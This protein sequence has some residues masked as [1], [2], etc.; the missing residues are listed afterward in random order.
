MGR[1]FKL[2]DNMEEVHLNIG[3]VVSV[4]NRYAD[5]GWRVYYTDQ[6]SRKVEKAEAM[7]I[8]ALLDAR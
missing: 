8:I 6:R 4:E 1:V 2:A 3:Q 7:E 5:I